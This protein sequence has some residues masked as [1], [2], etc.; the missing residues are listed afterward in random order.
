MTT[1][2]LSLFAAC[3]NDDF[4]SNGQGIQNGEAALR[5][6]VDVTLNVLGDG[7][8]DTRLVYE[9][10]Y[11]WED[12]D[13]IGALLMDELVGDER[14]YDDLEAWAEKPWLQRYELVDYINTNYPF[15]RENGQWST[16]AKMLEG[17]YFFAHPF[18][19]YDGNREAVHSIGEQKQYGQDLERAYADNQFFIGYSRIHAGTQS[20]EVMSTNLE[21]IPTLGS[22]TIQV[23][24]VGTEPFTVKKIVL[25]TNAKDG[26][27]STLLKIDPTN[28][29]YTG[30]TEEADPAYNLE[31]TNLSSI[32]WTNN[33]NANFFNYANYEEMY[34]NGEVE[35]GSTVWYFNDEFKEEYTEGGTL[36]NNTE[37]SINYNRKA[38]LRAVV[39][40]VE[41]DERAELIVENAPVLAANG[42]IGNYMV[43]TNA[44][45]YLEAN[46]NEISAYIYTNRGLVGPVA[47][48]GA[49]FEL[50]KGTEDE[51]KKEGVTVISDSPVLT[52]GPNNAP[53][54]KMAID[55]NSVQAPQTMPVYNED[56]L[57][58]FIEWN[59][60]ATVGRVNTVTLMNDITLTKEMTDLLT[61][62][63]WAKS[64]LAFLEYEDNDIVENSK[65]LTIA[66]D[67]A[68][69][70]MDYILV[71]GEVEVE[72]NLVLGTASYVN[73]EYDLKSIS[74]NP[75]RKI[76]HQKLTIAENA[77]VTVA[78][79]IK[80]LKSGE[81][82]YQALVVA[83]N[84]GTLNFNAVVEQLTV[85]ENKGKM[86]IN[87][88]VT[89]VGDS[90]NMK[91]A[92]IT[93]GEGAQ[94]SANGK[95][96]NMGAGT[97]EEDA[98]YAVI[99]NNGRI[100]NLKNGKYGKVI[101][102]A[103]STTN[104]DSNE[105]IIDI[106][107]NILANWK[108]NGGTGVISFTATKEVALADVIKS[109][110]TELVVNG[111]EVTAVEKTSS[112]SQDD[113]KANAVTKIVIKENGGTIGSDEFDANK[114]RLTWRS[115]FPNATTV[116]TNGNAALT[117]VDLAEATAINVKS[118]VTSINGKVEAKK[119]IVT[120]GS[121][122]SK[123]YIAHN[124]TLNLETKSDMLYVKN[125][126]KTTDPHANRVTA[127]VDNQGDIY[128]LKGQT[129]IK[130][131]E[132]EED[133][134]DWDGD[135]ESTFDPETTLNPIPDGT[136]TVDGSTIKTLEDLSKELNSTTN[137]YNKESLTTIVI[138]SD[139]DMTQPANYSNVDIL[140]NKNIELGA[141]MTG[142]SANYAQTVKSIKLTADVQIGTG[143]AD[144]TPNQTI[145]TV[146]DKLDF[147][148][149]TL[150]L[151]HGYLQIDGEYQIGS[152]CDKIVKGG[153]E[154][155]LL[156]NN[157]RIVTK[158]M[159]SSYEELIQ[160]N[161]KDNK[162]E[163]LK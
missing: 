13:E 23:K 81:M 55:N 39:K 151:N 6:Q 52:I 154:A 100:N 130:N 150:T 115:Q 149:N 18:A 84:E 114:N 47:L 15:K 94:V 106:S 54:V 48:N 27:L 24:N 3:T 36:V 97:N 83:E 117:D 122:D 152:G 16:G 118:G 161:M 40:P 129:I 105:G 21:M 26:G 7:D 119:A 93:I 14:P 17:N 133:G 29:A 141:N 70:I 88:N 28:A 37:K 107:A 19:T 158:N 62:G 9:N 12:G 157:G 79:D 82:K 78:S 89:F 90:Q 72:N 75:T 153:T 96:T 46:E 8:A 50:D 73:G 159:A 104:A 162:W 25:S 66:A 156:G 63:G 10:G 74:S 127:A 139:L 140:A 44:Y 101:A 143:G 76:E 59:V 92:T 131:D 144:V 111:G 45:Q 123:K 57:L 91:N 138:N 35:N 51:A 108:V 136:L 64:K 65:K 32:D 67:A 4:I 58:K 98:E 34:T 5:P 22:V 145:V 109:G 110:L 116:E 148:N 126:Q 142:W 30:E 128:I 49:N 38:A 20:G 41:G 102:G 120:L 134:I 60:D 132:D 155:E 95:L 121:Y 69:N 2:L 42:G 147:N 112:N 137:N 99:K 85:T 86:N 103:T 68:A 11:D 146:T 124:G 135:K 163:V 71:N 87:K 56:D 31:A 33:T 53:V 80:N 43:M 61:A 1:A 77:S 113:A 160:W 125:I